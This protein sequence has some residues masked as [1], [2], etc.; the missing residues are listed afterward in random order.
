MF[1][2]DKRILSVLFCLNPQGDD[3]LN[4]FFLVKETDVAFKISKKT[5]SNCFLIE[6]GCYNR[7]KV[8]TKKNAGTLDLG[9]LVPSSFEIFELVQGL[10]S[11]VWLTIIF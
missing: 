1:W 11:Y 4:D 10:S 3:V 2:I 5:E 7:I 8:S 6:F 9:I